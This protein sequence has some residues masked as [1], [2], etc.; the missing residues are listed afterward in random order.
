MPKVRMLATAIGPEFR[1]EEGS[2]VD[3]PEGLARA[4]VAG[5]YAEAID[6]LPDRS[7]ETAEARSGANTTELPT[8]KKK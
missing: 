4:W 8:G 7:P 6:P 1:A 2:I 5:S 3:V